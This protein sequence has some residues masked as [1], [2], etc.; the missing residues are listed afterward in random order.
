MSE[1][2]GGN[3]PAGV[4]EPFGVMEHSGSWLEWCC[5][6]LYRMLIRWWV[7]VCACHCIYCHLNKNSLMT[8]RG[9]RGTWR[10]DERLFGDECWSSWVITCQRKPFFSLDAKTGK[11][12]SGLA[13]AGACLHPT[14]QHENDQ[15]TKVTSVLLFTALFFQFWGCI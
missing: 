7:P 14:K 10:V 6:G 15:G 1:E 8:G 9:R 3:C 4:R 11:H 13:R 12:H 2:G 5:M